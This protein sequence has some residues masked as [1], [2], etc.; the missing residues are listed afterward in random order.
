MTAE[1]PIEVDCQTV[2]ARLCAEPGFV[3]IDCREPDEH[4]IVNIAAARLLPMSQLA[5]RLSE[6]EPLRAAPLVIHCHH[7]GRSLK[8]ANWL[9]AAG[10]ANA[11]SMA[12]GIDQW[13][14]EI[15]PTLAR[16]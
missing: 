2:A 6:L 8:V 16:Y 4:A 14:A 5:A 1:T 3:L 7:G 15:D 13:A 12:G 9:R 11:Q 10:F